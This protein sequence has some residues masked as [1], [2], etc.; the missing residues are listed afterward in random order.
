MVAQWGTDYSQA[1]VH[2]DRLE[3]GQ[4]KVE[5]WHMV[6]V[7]RAEHLRQARSTTS[8]AINVLY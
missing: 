3:A 2:T 7:G 6:A 4:R 8:P 1:A 5:R